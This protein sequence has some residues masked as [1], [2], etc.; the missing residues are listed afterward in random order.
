MQF[1]NGPVFDLRSAEGVG[2]VPCA[3]YGTCF[4]ACVDGSPEDGRAGR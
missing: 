3:S 2:W 1:V 4:D